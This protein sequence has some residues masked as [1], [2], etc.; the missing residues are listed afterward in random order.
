MMLKSLVALFALLHTISAEAEANFYPSGRTNQGRFLSNF[1]FLDKKCNQGV[2]RAVQNNDEL[3]DFLLVI[4]K[5]TSHAQQI[6]QMY[7][8]LCVD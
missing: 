1:E 2:P 6:L 4:I 7:F 3:E 5:S 8:L